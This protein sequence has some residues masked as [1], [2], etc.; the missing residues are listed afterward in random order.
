MNVKAQTLA[1]DLSKYRKV[2]AILMVGGG[3]LSLLG[4]LLNLKEF[5]YTWLVSFM[6]F[7]SIGLGGLFL[8]PVQGG[9]PRALTSPQAPGE[10]HVN[11]AF[12]PDGAVLVVH[13]GRHFGG[14]IVGVEFMA[15]LVAWEIQT[16]KQLWHHIEQ[17]A[18][19]RF[20]FSADG[21]G[22]VMRPDAARASASSSPV[23]PGMRMSATTHDTLRRRSELIKLSALENVVVE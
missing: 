23:I 13:L 8:V 4:A 11:A 5:A 22:I 3:V 2:P 1:L 18:P 14:H 12:S 7:L 6:F 17:D 9:E 21:K 10:R 20:V 15:L 16:G 19:R